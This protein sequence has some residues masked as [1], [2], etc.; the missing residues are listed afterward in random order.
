MTNRSCLHRSPELAVAIVL[1]VIYGWLV[2]PGNGM[3]ATCPVGTAIDYLAPLRQL[4]QDHPLPTDGHLPFAPRHLI[5]TAP[6]SLLL[7]GEAVEIT[8]GA[9]APHASYRLG[10]TVTLK[11]RRVDPAGRPGRLVGQ[12]R[13]RFPGY[14]SYAT[15]PVDLRVR[16]LDRIGI[17]RSDI[18]IAT[19]YRRPTTFRQYFRVVKR[20]VDVNLHVDKAAYLPGETVAARL[21]D[22][23]TTSITTVP[24]FELQGWNGT[25]WAPV[26]GKPTWFSGPA[27]SLP[28][29]AVGNCE[30]FPLP[31]NLEPGPYRLAKPVSIGRR[32]RAVY[33]YFQVE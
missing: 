26:D 9:D 10:W 33:A 17:Y 8:L 24:N 29:G 18:M 32:G 28:A 16:D 31:A 5:V 13:R 21:E 19:G 7:A 27:T 1:I 3:A 30:H 15:N 2:S 20:K 12:R 11:V 22:R 4:P 25:Q 14:R 6:R 23:G